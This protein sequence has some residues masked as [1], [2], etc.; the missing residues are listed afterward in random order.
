MTAPETSARSDSKFDRYHAVRVP[1]VQVK[2]YLARLFSYFR[3]SDA[4][5]ITS[6]IYV[7]RLLRRHEDF[8]LTT[9]SIHRILAVSMLLSA[10]FNDDTYY[11]NDYY[12]KVCGM[13]LKELNVLEGQFLGFV[14]WNLCVTSDEYDKY[15]NYV[16]AVY[17]SHL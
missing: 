12:A 15:R 8:C 2:S 4:C 11:S 14:D 3:C 10:K 5:L 13:S 17:S 7:D 16:L 6:L 1:S 9:L